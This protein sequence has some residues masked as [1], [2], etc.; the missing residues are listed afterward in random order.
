MRI[1]I[2][3]YGVVGSSMFRFISRNHEHRAY[4]YD[5]FISP[6]DTDE[7]RT[8]VMTCDLVFLCVPTRSTPGTLACDLSAVEECVSW[9]TAPICIRSTVIPGTVDRLSTMN[10]LPIAF[11]PEYIGEQPGHPWTDETDPGFLIVGGPISVYELVRDLYLSF[12]HQPLHIHH[13]DA[14]TAELCKYM[15]NCFLATKV[16]FVNQFFDISTAFGVDFSELRRLWLADPRIGE[17]HTTVTLE[18]GFGGRCLPKDLAALIAAMKPYGGA[19][20]LEAVLLCNSCLCERPSHSPPT[21]KCHSSL[22][23]KQL[24]TETA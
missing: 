17:S 14:I 12:P 24:T 6:Y 19:P 4:V 8:A 7:H 10:A 18:R 13:T 23:S 2:V 16:A 15:E 3:G 11:C 9:I 5:K 20:L 1:G 22:L 21:I